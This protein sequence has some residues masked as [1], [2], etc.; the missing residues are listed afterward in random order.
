MF[1]T[2]VLLLPVQAPLST[3]A[4]HCSVFTLSL[5]ASMLELWSV[6]LCVDMYMEKMLLV[7]KKLFVKMFS[8]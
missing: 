2:K 3:C 8:M 6:K 1:G 5:I 4:A 7:P